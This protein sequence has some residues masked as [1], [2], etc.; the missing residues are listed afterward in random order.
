LPD[1]EVDD[2][3][4]QIGETQAALRDSIARARELA[5]E[6]DRLILESTEAMKPPNPEPR[7]A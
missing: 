5:V 4:I 7:E 3:F 2:N 6:A 1:K